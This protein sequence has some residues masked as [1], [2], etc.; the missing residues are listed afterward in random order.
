MRKF[1]TWTFLVF[2]LTAFGQSQKLDSLMLTGEYE[3]VLTAVAAEE[4][5]LPSA[6]SLPILQNKKAE[7]L[8]HLGRFEEAEKTLRNLKQEEDLFHQGITHTNYGLLYMNQGRFDLAEQSLLEAISR[9]ENTEKQETLEAAQAITNLGLVYNAS[10]SYSKAKD[11]L[12]RALAIREK[13]VSPDH[14]L[15]AA[16]Y[17]DLGLAY[18]NIDN[19]KALDYYE[20]ALDIYKR[21]HGAGHPKIAIANINNGL[22]YRNLELYGDATNNFE[23]ALKIW[24]TVYPSSHP[25]KAFALMNL[26]QT[27]LM[28]G[29][30][31]AAIGYYERAL[32]M[33]RES[34][35][36]KHPDIAQ[37]LNALGNIQ[38]S[39]ENFDAGLQRYQEAIVA[40]TTGFSQTS[41]SINPPLKNFYNGYVLLYSMLFKAEAFEKQYLGKTLRFGD[42][43]HS[44]STLQ[45]CDSLI[46]MLRQ[47]TSNENDK[48][49]LGVIANDVYADGVRVASELALN[50]VKKKEYRELAF[51]FAEKSKSAVLLESISD[52][53]AK[54]F[55]GIPNSVMEEEKALKSEIALA[56]QKLA[57]K[58]DP[59]SEKQLRESA[60]TLSR[61]YETFIKTL[62]R[63]YPSYFNLKFNA[64]SPSISQIQ[65][66]LENNTAVIS[67]FIDDR[68]SRLYTF[69][70]TKKSYRVVEKTIP[71]ELDKYITGLRNSIYFSEMKS[72]ILTAGKLGEL[73]IPRVP[74]SITSLVILPTGRLSVIPFE[75]LLTTNKIQSKSFAT[76][77]YLIRHY[78][79]RYEFSASLLLQKTRKSAASASSILMYAPVNFPNVDGLPE[80]PG[81]EAEVRAISSLFAE[82]NR[83]ATVNLFEKANESVIKE[84]DISDYNI[85]HLATHGVVDEYNPEL[86]RIFLQT[87]TPAEDGN[88]F[89]GEI[90]NL[91]LKADLVTLSA[92]QT[93]LGKISKG[94]GVIGLSRALV[95]AGAQNIIVSYW[96]V[97]DE[98]TADLMK[99]FYR[100]LLSNTEGGNFHSALRSAKLS[101]MEGPKFASPYYW[102][103]FI[104]IGY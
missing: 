7:A 70:I 24:E 87:T 39:E 89:A 49:A 55:A 6:G 29:N 64:T 40:N 99:E 20:K 36:E 52:A 47:Q 23:N 66:G 78:A 84:T 98:S 33:Y 68:N 5:L 41:S 51:Y 37:V 13:I 22:I 46:D 86:S 82:K 91:K 11:Q 54:S 79:V 56:T 30:P 72:Y 14:E 101:L 21:I 104:L 76:L 3:G 75:A 8:I 74:R 62:E 35:G 15:L 26:G 53:N 28:T 85:L 25:T 60:Y 102:A 42:L 73:L 19:D 9:F 43:V 103:P 95:Y 83:T 69:V 44:L 38:V 31:K 57:Q 32:D 100:V 58:P 77:S 59:A 67:Y 2:S 90:Y 71:K 88:L 63:D 17:N 92:C 10:G 81:T 45:A 96:S 12:M 50:A 1:F 34:Y 18:A 94:E 93:G 61:R 16:S 27:Y 4:K 65:K 80:L 97:A 48:I